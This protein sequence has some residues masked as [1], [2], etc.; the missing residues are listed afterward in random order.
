MCLITKQQKSIVLKEDLIVYKTLVRTSEENTFCSVLHN[1]W[2]RLGELNK[3]K[4]K[5]EKVILD[6]MIL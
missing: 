6:I 3:T 2:Y 1:F 4:I 5:V